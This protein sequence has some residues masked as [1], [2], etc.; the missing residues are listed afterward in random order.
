MLH[1]TVCTSLIACERLR[2][3]DISRN[4]LFG[5]I[6]T[7]IGDFK[8]LE[9]L[10][11]N[12]NKFS[13]H[14]P[15]HIFNASKIEV[16]KLQSNTL[17]G[18]IPTQVGALS[19]ARIISFSHNSLQ[20]TIPTEFEMLKN[21]EYLHLNN[22]LLTGVAPE[23]KFSRRVPNAYVADCGD[24]SFLLADE[25]T[26]HSCTMCCN[27]EDKCQKNLSMN[28]SLTVLAFAVTLAITIGFTINFGIISKLKQNGILSII[29]DNRDPLNFFQEDSV[30]CFIYTN[31]GIAYFIDFGTFAI[32]IWLFTI[33]LE[34]SNLK[35]KESDWQFTYRCPNNNMVCMNMNS[36]TTSGWIIFVILAFYHLGTDL[37]R[38]ILK[39]KKSMLTCN[40]IMLVSGL[41]LLG[42]TSLAIFTS[43]YYNQALAE[44]NTDL[45]M[46]AVILLFINDL[47]ER[48]MDVIKTMNPNWLEKRY[49]EA[50]E[51]LKKE[52]SAILNQRI[53]AGREMLGI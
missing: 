39:I 3:L 2:I 33:Y 37:A 18:S 25:L 8:F 11:L 24:P 9:E 12:E 17:A 47:D 51:N 53:R 35:N 42:L 28:M 14:I 6:P 34:A 43:I 30:Y 40:C 22:N 49:E 52:H 27:S 31:S 38:G 4:N 26:C 41:R 19:H 21:L 15:S 50:R 13:G 48:L 20:G 16:L 7:F 5:S 44:K 32:Q 23:L 10:K 36:V 45:V 1:G 29:E 46:N